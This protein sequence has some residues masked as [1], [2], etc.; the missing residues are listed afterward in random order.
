MSQAHIAVFK[1]KTLALI[2]VLHLSPEEVIGLGLSL[3]ASYAVTAGIGREATATALAES[4][5]LVDASLPGIAMIKGS[6]S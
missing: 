3:A 1:S 6:A 4:F 5:E 2:D